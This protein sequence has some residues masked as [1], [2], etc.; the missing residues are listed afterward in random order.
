MFYVYILRS[1]SSGLFYVGHTEDLEQR[2]QEHEEG[3]SHYTKGRGP[4]KSVYVE[5]FSTRSEAMKRECLIKKRKS[6]KYI[7]KL[8]DEDHGE[9]RKKMGK[10]DDEVS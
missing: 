5:V 10:K 4:W 9:W 1:D 6:R 2:I 8:I 7:E 3:R